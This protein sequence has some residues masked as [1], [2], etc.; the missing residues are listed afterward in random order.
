MRLRFEVTQPQAHWKLRRVLQVFKFATRER[1]EAAAAPPL[2]HAG[3]AQWQAARL[4]WQCPRARALQAVTAPGLADGTG[5]RATSSREST[6][7]LPVRPGDSDAPGA[8]SSMAQC[9]SG[10]RR[11]RSARLAEVNW[12]DTASAV[13]PTQ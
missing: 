9:H 12:C 7:S 1:G 13:P 6:S 3:V 5:R 11:R 10:P 4:H 2:R 8:A